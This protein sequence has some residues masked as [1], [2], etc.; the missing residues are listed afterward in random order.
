MCGD[1]SDGDYSGPDSTNGTVVGKQQSDT[2]SRTIC[3]IPSDLELLPPGAQCDLAAFKMT[4][5][6]DENHTVIPTGFTGTS[7][8]RQVFLLI[9]KDRSTILGF[10]IY[11]SI[12]LADCNEELT[13]LAKSLRP[14]LII[15][16]NTSIAKAIA[17]S[18]HAVEQ[19]MPVLHQQ[20]FPSS[21]HV[22][23]HASWMKHTDRDRL[24]FACELTCGK[25]MITIMGMLDTGEDVIVILY[26]FGPESGT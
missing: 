19:A 13:V 16:E 9:G 3:R 11:P 20:D 1:T 21:E 14:P 5:F 22:E 2:L 18:C 4:C 26:F 23:V 6:M 24:I 7:W 8:K 10:V 15:P 17:L 12:I 25:K